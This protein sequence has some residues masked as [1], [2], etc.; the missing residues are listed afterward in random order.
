MK[1]RPDA[2]GFTVV[3]LLITIGICGVLVP[4]LALGLANLTVINNRSRD[5]ALANMLA[6]NKA[7]LLRSAGFNSLDVG[8]VDFSND[9]PNVL[10]SPKSATYTITN[11]QDSIKEIS[12]DISYKDYNTVRTINYKTA[13]SEIGVAQ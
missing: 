6:Q 9:L 12:I 2:T 1:L 10:A 5:L 13:V 4:S 11:S 8:T 7:E 3:E